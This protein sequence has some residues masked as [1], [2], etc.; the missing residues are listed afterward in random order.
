[1]SETSA[2]VAE[3]AARIFEDLADPQT[4]NQ[5]KDDA[6]QAPLWASLEESGLT[7]TELHLIEESL[8]KSLTALFHARIRYPEPAKVTER[9]S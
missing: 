4:V 7:L 3:T 6:W 8:C 5:A 1:M 2:I 9:A